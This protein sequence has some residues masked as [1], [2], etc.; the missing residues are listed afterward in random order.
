VAF[1]LVGLLKQMPTRAASP[2]ADLV[3]VRVCFETG[4]SVDGRVTAICTLPKCISAGCRW[5]EPGSFAVDIFAS[6]SFSDMAL[7][8]RTTAGDVLQDRLPADGRSADPR[9]RVQSIIRRR[10]L[11]T[12]L[13]F[14]R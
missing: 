2:L 3:A 6:A 5:I 11:L 13:R 4:L 14:L 9:A 12:L 8:D 10:L 1:I 7:S